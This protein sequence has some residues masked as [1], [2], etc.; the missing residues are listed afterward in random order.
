MVLRVLVRH[1]GHSSR[2]FSVIKH[3][4]LP[5][6]TRGWMTGKLEECQSSDSMES[7][8]SDLTAA[9]ASEKMLIG[10]QEALMVVTNGQ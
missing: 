8:T 2:L 7:H 6:L 9:R 1:R 3:G 4:R 5:Q 10:Q